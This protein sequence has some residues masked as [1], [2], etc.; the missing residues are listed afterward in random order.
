MPSP[1]ISRSCCVSIFCV[2]PS[3]A[4]ISSEKRFVPPKRC[5]RIS[6]FHRPPMTSSVASAGHPKVLFFILRYP[7]GKYHTKRYVLYRMASACEAHPMRIG[8]LGTGDVGRA[9]G[10]GFVKYGHQVK[11]GSRDANNE[12]AKA[13]AAETGPAASSGDF[14]D[15]ARSA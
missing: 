5:H 7:T 13:W 12:K 11:M 1:S 15:T 10:K 6:V 8:I 4:R 9:L 14:A 3:T 2:I